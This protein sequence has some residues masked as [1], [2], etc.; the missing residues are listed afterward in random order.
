MIHSEQLV[1]GEELKRNAIFKRIKNSINFGAEI[2]DIFLRTATSLQVTVL[3]SKLFDQ[4]LIIG[5]THLYYHPD[6][7]LTR[8]IQTAM[9]TEFLN[10]LKQKLQKVNVV[11]HI[12]RFIQ[13]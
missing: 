6:A 10:H 12:D 2:T 1:L 3:K 5:N 8:V 4:R 7:S 9:I 13:V 11:D